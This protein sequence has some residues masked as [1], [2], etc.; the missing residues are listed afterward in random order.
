[1]VPDILA[2]SAE[3]AGKAACFGVIAALCDAGNQQTHALRTRSADCSWWFSVTDDR[4]CVMRPAPSVVRAT[5]VLPAPEDFDDAHGA[6][7]AGARLTQGEWDDFGFMSWCGGLFRVLDAQQGADIRDVGLAGRA[8]QPAVVPNAVEPFRPDMDEEPANELRRGQSHLFLAVAGLD[9]VVFPAERD[10]LGIRADEAGARDRH[11]VSISAQVGQHRLWPHRRA[12]WHRPPTR[13][14][15]TVRATWQT[16]LLL[17]IRP[18][19]RRRQ[20]CLN[21]VASS[22]LPETGVGTAATAPAHV[23][24]PLSMPAVQLGTSSPMTQ[25]PSHQ[26]P[27]AHGQRSFGRAVGISRTVPSAASIPQ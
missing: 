23:S 18:D 13:I 8:G 10:R 6:A 2:H 1:M 16:P 24:Y 12:V 14:C 11:A 19:R 17:T 15:E 3:D 22:A 21:C 26:S 5:S 25:K 9:P 27:P 4:R 7:A 20:A